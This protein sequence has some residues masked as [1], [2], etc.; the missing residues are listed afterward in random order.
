M[1]KSFLLETDILLLRHAPVAS[2]VSVE[3]QTFQHLL[4][5]VWYSS[6][7]ILNL[8]YLMGSLES[9]SDEPKPNPQTK[10]S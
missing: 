9:L 7:G 2:Y 5:V 4:L 1:T 6:A 10:E 8:P 3:N